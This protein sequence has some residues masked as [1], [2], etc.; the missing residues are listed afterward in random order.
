M[1]PVPAVQPVPAASIP[2][3]LPQAA[4]SSNAQAQVQSKASAKDKRPRP[5]RL[6]RLCRKLLKQRPRR[7]PRA[8][9]EAE[10]LALRRW[11]ITPRPWSHPIFKAVNKRSLAESK[12]R[13]RRTSRLTIAPTPRNRVSRHRRQLPP[14][15]LRARI[16]SDRLRIHTNQVVPRKVK[17]WSSR[18]IKIETTKQQA[19]ISKFLKEEI[20]NTLITPSI[21]SRGPTAS[22]VQGRTL[23]PNTNFLRRQVSS[24]LVSNAN[25]DRGKGYAP[26][27]PG[28]EPTPVKTEV[29]PSGSKQKLEDPADAPKSKKPLT[30][31]E[32]KLLEVFRSQTSSSKPAV[33]RE[34]VEKALRQVKRIEDEL[35]SLEEFL[36]SLL[37]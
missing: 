37:L 34:K 27:K 25:K 20:I 3:D 6:R 31:A 10:S 1:K 24:L 11:L 15:S 30:E 32:R 28:A 16:L 29:N 21:P 17:G 14:W 4:S 33:D 7:Q 5:N 36:K 12:R 2:E 23:R 9:R 8:T 26:V 22:F 18:T 13:T 35:D 19:K